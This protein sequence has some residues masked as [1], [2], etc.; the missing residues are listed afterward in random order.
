MSVFR[1]YLVPISKSGQRQ[2]EKEGCEDNIPTQKRHSQLMNLL[3]SN[4]IENGGKFLYSPENAR[5]KPM[6]FFKKYWKKITGRTKPGLILNSDQTQKSSKTLTGKLT[7]KSLSDG[8]FLFTTCEYLIAN[9]GSILISSNQIAEKKLNELPKNFIVFATTSQI[10]K[11]LG[12]TSWHKSQKQK[13]YSYKH[14]N[15]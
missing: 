13:K 5:M 1:K 2:P 3:Q 4:L 6:N 15:H 11:P 8:H 7:V 9:D 10:V 12:R 14:H